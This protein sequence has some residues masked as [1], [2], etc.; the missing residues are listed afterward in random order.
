MG[1]EKA[2]LIFSTYNTAWGSFYCDPKDD[3]LRAEVPVQLMTESKERVTYEFSNQTDT[4]AIESL[5]WE[6]MKSMF[7]DVH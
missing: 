2:T 4:T 3:A 6:K 7:E 1:P 5:Q